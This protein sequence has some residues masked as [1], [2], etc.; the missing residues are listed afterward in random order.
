[1]GKKR[2]MATPNK[3]QII[4]KATELDPNFALVFAKHA[5]VSIVLYTERD[6]PSKE[7]LEKVFT[8]VST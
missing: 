7:R 5:Y 1:M 3:Q 2:K 4:E 8:E 6:D